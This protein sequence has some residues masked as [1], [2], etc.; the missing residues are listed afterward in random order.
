M[1]LIHCIQR[2]WR[3]LCPYHL[4]SISFPNSEDKL[5]TNVTWFALRFFHPFSHSTLFCFQ[6]LDNE[7]NKSEIELFHASLRIQ[8][9]LLTYTGKIKMQSK[10]Q[11]GKISSPVQ[12]PSNELHSRLFFC[13]RPVTLHANHSF[14]RFR[15]HPYL[16]NQR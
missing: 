8:T 2:L 7:I 9:E 11:Q 6:T 10:I 4:Y 16:I 14:L 15:F 3:N 5:N 12:V 13:S 1:T